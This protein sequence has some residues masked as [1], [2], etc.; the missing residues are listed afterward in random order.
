M[1]VRNKVALQSAGKTM[2]IPAGFRGVARF[3][4]SG[5]TQMCGCRRREIARGLMVMCRANVQRMRYKAK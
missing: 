1:N 5:G 4:G 3:A 2:S